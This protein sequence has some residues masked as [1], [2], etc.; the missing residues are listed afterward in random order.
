M[1]WRGRGAVSVRWTATP[2][3][4]VRIIQEA[5]CFVFGLSSPCNVIAKNRGVFLPL[6]RR[7]EPLLNCRYHL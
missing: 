1:Y 4:R 6:L 7:L 5:I 2:A 3:A